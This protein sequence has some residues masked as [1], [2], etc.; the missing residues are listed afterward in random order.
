VPIFLKGGP[1][2]TGDA[3]CRQGNGEVNLTAIE[4]AFREIVLHPIV[5]EELTLEWPRMENS[6]PGS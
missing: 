4:C 1:I 6:T 2:G 3:H 5:L